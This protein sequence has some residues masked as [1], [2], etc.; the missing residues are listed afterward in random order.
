MRRWLASS[1]GPSYDGP[2][3]ELDGDLGTEPFNAAGESVSERS[4]SPRS[5]GTSEEVPDAGPSPATHNE[6]TF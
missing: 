6:A 1:A 3:P 4:L 2:L 5:D